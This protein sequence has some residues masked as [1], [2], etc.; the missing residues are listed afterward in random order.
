MFPMHFLLEIVL[1]TLFL[2]QLP[3]AVID[4]AIQNAKDLI[5]AAY[6]RGYKDGRKYATNPKPFVKYDP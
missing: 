4:K 5:D 6:Q 1:E 2:E 3:P